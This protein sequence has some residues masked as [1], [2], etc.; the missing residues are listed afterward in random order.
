V[1]VHPIDKLMC[2]IPVKFAV[3]PTGKT[4]YVCLN[5][6]FYCEHLSVCL[7]MHYCIAFDL[8]MPDWLKPSHRC[9]IYFFRFFIFTFTTETFERTN[10]PKIECSFACIAGGQKNHHQKTRFKFPFDSNWNLNRIC[11]GK[12]LNW[13]G[14]SVFYTCC[15]LCLSDWLWKDELLCWENLDVKISPRRGHCRFFIFS[16][17]DIW[18]KSAFFQSAETLSP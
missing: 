4:T 18:Q 2:I 9:S 1:C 6:F 11:F 5:V 15:L 8:S 17:L 7:S 13:L 12:M 16:F 3:P 10:Q 14:S